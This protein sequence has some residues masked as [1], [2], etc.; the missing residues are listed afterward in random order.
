MAQRG[1]YELDN[2]DFRSAGATQ[3]KMTATASTLTYEGVAAADVVV[4]GVD[5]ASVYVGTDSANKEYAIT[6]QYD[7]IVDAGGNGTHTLLSAAVTAGA[8]SIYIK[9]GTYSESTNIDFSANAP[10]HIVGENKHD[11]IIDFGT[12]NV[13]LI[14]NGGGT[15][16]ITGTVSITSGGT[17]VVGVGTLFSTQLSSGDYILLE[18]TFYEIDTITDATN[19]DLVTIYNGVTLSGEAYVGLPLIS[20]TFQNFTVQSSGTGTA[21]QLIL[22]STISAIVEDMC[23]KN[24]RNNAI[25]FNTL[26][27]SASSTQTLINKCIIDS[28]QNDGINIPLEFQ[29]NI[30]QTIIKNPGN[31]G[32]NINLCRNLVVKWVEYYKL[33]R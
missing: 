3:V 28:P 5:N 7:A 16:T 27:G 20:G 17:A 33:W 23:F 32:L 12:N 30:T 2:I 29:G 21:N 10:V 8:S 4:A 24:A 15:P 26:V 11:T 31:I 25:T 13:G 6:T 1:R 19:L 22:S 9:S 18:E 14:L